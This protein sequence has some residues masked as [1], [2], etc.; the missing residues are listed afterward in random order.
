MSEQTTASVPASGMDDDAPPPGTAVVRPL[1]HVRAVRE[2]HLQ[3][4]AERSQGPE[5]RSARAWSWAL[6]E[7]AVAPVT[8]QPTGAPPSRSD[9]EA[10]IAVAD[11]RR[12][13]GDRDNRAD[14]AATVLLWLIGEDDHIPVRGPNRG[15]LV[16]GFGDVVRSL[17]Q[18]QELVTTL[19]LRHDPPSA[20]GIEAQLNDADYLNGVI[21]TLRWVGHKHAA[22]PISGLRTIQVTTRDLKAERVLAEDVIEQLGQQGAGDL[23]PHSYGTGVLN[24]SLPTRRG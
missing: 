12:L 11:E 5:S 9:I 6:G 20:R 19:I 23:L 22:A 14:G 24:A 16:G 10:E 17:N 1:R 18:I 21:A 13:R 8:D 3:Q 7:T 15:E 4:L 2:R